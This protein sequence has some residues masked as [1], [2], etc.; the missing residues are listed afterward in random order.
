MVSSDK[1]EQLETLATMLIEVRNR[2][3]KLDLAP[4]FPGAARLHGEISNCHGL[5]SQLAMRARFA[6][7][8]PRKQAASPGN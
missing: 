4:T 7:E 8:H 6:V 5:A 2:L 3:E 1:V